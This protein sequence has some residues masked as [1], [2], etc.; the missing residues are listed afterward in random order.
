M[1]QKREPDETIEVT[2]DGDKVV[3]YSF[4]SGGDVLFCLND[5]PGPYAGLITERLVDHRIRHHRSGEPGHCITCP[6]PQS[7]DFP[8]SSHMPFY[9]EPRAYRETLLGFRAKHGVKA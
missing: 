9:E 6:T 4:G 5:G 7:K 3:V 8:N 2:V 1:W